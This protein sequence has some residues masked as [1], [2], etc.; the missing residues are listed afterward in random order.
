MSHKWWSDDIYILKGKGQLHCDLIML[1][2]NIIQQHNSGTGGVDWFVE[3]DNCKVVTVVSD[4]TLDGCVSV[5]CLEDSWT[6][7]AFT[8]HTSVCCFI[9][10]QS[11]AILEALWPSTSASWIS[12]PGPCSY[13]Q[14]W[15]SPSR[16]F[17]VGDWIYHLFFFIVTVCDTLALQNVILRLEWRHVI[18]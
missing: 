12:T 11:T 18:F 9:Q 5:S 10:I 2:K 1:C 3:A 15:A 17:Q 13:Q 6:V 8:P 7:R 4:S 16:T 14:C